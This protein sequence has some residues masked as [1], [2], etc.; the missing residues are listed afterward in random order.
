MGH[1]RGISLDKVCI[2]H[3]NIRD[4][5]RVLPV[6]VMSC[7]WVPLPR[8][9]SDKVYIDLATI[10]A[11]LRVLPISVVSCSRAPPP[12]IGLE[13]FLLDPCFEELREHT[14]PANV[15]VSHLQLES[16]FGAGAHKSVTC[17]TSVVSTCLPW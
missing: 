16:F 9:A 7:K 10:R 6:N 3:A 11:G 14:G 17:P 12:T 13:K 1:T 15:F 4:G 5:L 8:I 2:D